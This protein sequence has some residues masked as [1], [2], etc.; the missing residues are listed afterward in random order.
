MSDP[1]DDMSYSRGFPSLYN[2][3]ACE[4]LLHYV[5]IPRGSTMIH[6]PFEVLLTQKEDRD[7]QEKYERLIK[8]SSMHKINYSVMD[9]MFDAE[10]ARMMAQ[11]EANKRRNQY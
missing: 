2:S 8:N 4:V 7:K 11:D 1:R 5:D 6:S 3:N 9:K 10:V